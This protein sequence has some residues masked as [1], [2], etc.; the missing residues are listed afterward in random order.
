[1]WSK[2]S[3]LSLCGASNPTSRIAPNRG[4]ILLV[5]YFKYKEKSEEIDVWRY[6]RCAQ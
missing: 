5:I 1:M 6:V 4:G 3:T 2:N